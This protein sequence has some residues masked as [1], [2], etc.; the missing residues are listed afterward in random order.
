[1]QNGKALIATVIGIGISLALL[2]MYLIGGV[3]D[4]IQVWINASQ[5]WI[6]VST[7]ESTAW[8]SAWMPAS[9]RSISVWTGSKAQPSV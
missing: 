2:M 3:G 7:A 5:D 6:N 9:I 8:N 1:M 4:R